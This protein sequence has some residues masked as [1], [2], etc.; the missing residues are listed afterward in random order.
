[1]LRS[2]MTTGALALGL[3]LSGSALAIPINYD[4]GVSGDL[5]G[6]DLGAL[7]VGTNVIT[8]TLSGD[9]DDD[10]FLFTLVAGQQITD[11]AI[12]T[13]NGSCTPICVAIFDGRGPGGNLWAE[14]VDI[15]VA[16]TLTL[17][18]DFSQSTVPPYTTPGGYDISHESPDFLGTGGYDYV[19]QMTVTPIPEPGTALLVGGGLA[20]LALRRRRMPPAS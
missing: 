1:M 17:L 12:T 3:L 18:N 4:E 10:D 7:D 19:I 16:Q 11:V 13:S 6:D 9:N 8:G 5:A 14:N 2:W 15:D 20:A